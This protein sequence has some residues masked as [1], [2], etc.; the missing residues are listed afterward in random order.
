MKRYIILFVALCCAAVLTAG[1]SQRPADLTGN[2]VSNTSRD[3]SEASTASESSTASQPAA[4]S[5]ITGTQSAIE[6]NST[7]SSSISWHAADSTPSKAN[8][9]TV[10]PLASVPFGN[11]NNSLLLSTSSS[12]FLEGLW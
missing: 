5:V 1:C 4:V 12:E 6:Q 9:E 8:E 3:R 2:T 7:E 11:E 10:P